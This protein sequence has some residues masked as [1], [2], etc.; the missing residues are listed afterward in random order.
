MCMKLADLF[1]NYY[2]VRKE[3]IDAVG[4]MS[5]RQLAWV[6]EGHTNSIGRLLA[7]IAETEFWWIT[8]VALRKAEYSESAFERFESASGL[9]ECLA[10]LEE[11]LAD[12]TEY[13]QQ[14]TTDDWDSVFHDV[15]GHNE[16]VSMRWLA[17]HVIEHQARHRGQI[18]MMMHMQGLKVPDV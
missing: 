12:T 8:I 1:S 11:T 7:H 6:P 17:W 2:T 18:F 13:L 9:N 3:L 10:L 4:G 14:N 16:K 5:P 15:V